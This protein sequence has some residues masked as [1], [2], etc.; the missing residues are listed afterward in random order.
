MRF[1][2]LA[3]RLYSFAVLFSFQRIIAR[4]ATWLS[5]HEV[6]F[7]SNYFSIFSK[8]FSWCR[9][10]RLNDNNECLNLSTPFY[11]SI[12]SEVVFLVQAY[13]I[14]TICIF[15]VKSVNSRF[16]CFGFSCRFKSIHYR[17][18]MMYFFFDI[19]AV[20]GSLIGIKNNDST[21]YIS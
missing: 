12:V 11:V 21:T 19:S 3:H 5:Y 16:S 10:L 2:H 6:S 17:L 8:T 7:L 15:S 18:W 14:I 20:W 4:Q 1:L 9:E 13:V